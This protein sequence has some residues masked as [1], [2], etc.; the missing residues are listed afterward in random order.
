ML[1]K[2][3][4]PIDLTSPEAWRTAIDAAEDLARRYGATLAVL[5][6]APPTAHDPAALPE[7]Y[8]PM[9]HEFVAQRFADDITVEAHVRADWD[10]PV[11]EICHTADEVGADLIVMGTH[12]PQ[13]GEA[14]DDSNAAQVA[15]QAGCSVWVV[16][17]R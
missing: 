13:A 3:L 4:L 14:L 12:S 17:Q 16:R 8:L 1:K 6:V 15:L 10:D 5:W 11:R 7:T 2:I 9:L